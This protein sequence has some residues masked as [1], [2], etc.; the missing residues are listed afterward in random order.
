MGRVRFSKEII[1]ASILFCH[2]AYAQQSSVKI[3]TWWGY[4]E[5]KSDDVQKIEKKC[6]AKLSIDE[7]YSNSEFIDR[8]NKSKNTNKSYEIMI[9]SDTVS[10]IL[11]DAVNKK[12]VLDVDLRNYNSAIHSYFLEHKLGKNTGIFQL[13]LTGFLYNKKN[14]EINEIDSLDSIFR[15]VGSKVAVLVDDQVE[16]VTLLRRWQCEKHPATCSKIFPDFFPTD[17]SLKSLFGTAKTLITADLG[18]VDRH[19]DFALAY[20]WS[21]D[22]IARVEKNKNLGFVIHRGSGSNGCKSNA[23]RS[24]QV[25]S[26]AAI[27]P[28]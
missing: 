17:E 12:Q 25:I 18:T 15:K 26:M 27:G 22:S 28:F 14:I 2:G 16:I 1:C 20:T 11:Q 4:L 9:Y 7:F 13:S 19:P 5:N 23:K 10:E 6:N 3:I 21:G 8:I 24:F